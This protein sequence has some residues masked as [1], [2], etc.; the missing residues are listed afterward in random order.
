MAI[1]DQFTSDEWARVVQAP[2]LAGL[3]VTAADP[4]GLWGAIKEGASMAASVAKAKSGAA[5]GSLLSGV[6]GAFETSEGRRLMQDGVKELFK[7][8]KPGEASKLA[9]DRLGEI[10][11][12]VSQKAPTEAAAFKTWLREVAQNVAES[13]TEGGFL[14]FGG[15]KVSDEEKQ[16][17]ADI[18]RVLGG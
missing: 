15:E 2:M 6:V 7:G 11:R 10:A 1:K 12:L 17:L 14:G 5:D 16:T 8:K 18:D 13:S 4:G 3:A 9:V